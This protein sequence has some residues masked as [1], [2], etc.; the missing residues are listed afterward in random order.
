MNGA[1]LFL[2]VGAFVALLLLIRHTLRHEGRRRTLLL[3]GYLVLMGALREWLVRWLSAATD[4]PVPY[5]A[6][7]TLGQIG[8]LNL[9]V[10]AGWVFTVLL[11]F[12]LAKLIQRRNFPRTNIFFTLALSALVTTAISY[13]VETCGMRIHLWTWRQLL[14]VEWLPFDWPF[15]AFEG[16]AATSLVILL[17]Y[18]GLRYRL[19]SSRRWSSAAITAGLLTLFALAD[20]AQ[21]LL[22]PES[23]RKKVTVAYLLACIVLGFRAPQ[24]MLGSSDAAL[25]AHD[26]S[27]ALES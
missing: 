16:W 27:R 15:D 13:A 9:I 19:F 8:A 11:S 25:A 12:E 22:G 3:V 21:P 1:A 6:N 14:P 7:A 24:W 23:P 5:S 10:V 18:C 26:D 20:L 17:V 4:Q 2:R